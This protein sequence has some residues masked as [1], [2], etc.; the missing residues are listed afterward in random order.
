MTLEAQVDGAARKLIF[1]LEII[2]MAEDYNDDTVG[3]QALTNHIQR[4]ARLYGLPNW[5]V[6]GMVETHEEAPRRSH[7]VRLPDITGTVR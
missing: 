5:K 6:R 1:R 2:L 7:S 3:W 4:V